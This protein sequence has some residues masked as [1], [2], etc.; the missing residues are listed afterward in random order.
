[1]MET[2]KSLTLGSSILVPSVQELA[3]QT[4]AEIPPR[5]IRTM[6]MKDC[7]GIVTAASGIGQ[8]I[9]VINFQNL[10]SPEQSVGDLELE[11]LH[12]ACK[13]WGFF[14]LVNHGVSSSLVEKVK[15][16]VY[17]LFKLPMEE[18][19]RYWQQEE[20]VEGFGQAFVVSEEQKLD[21]AD[22][23]FMTTLPH[24]ARKP[25]L[26]PKLPQ[27]L[28]DTLESYSS[29]LKILAMKILGRMAKALEIESN[30][31]SE[32]FENG[33]QNMRMNY[34][35]PCPQPE[36]VIG[37]TSHSDGVG[38]TILLQLN[39]VEGLQIKKEDKWVS[40]KPLPHAFIIN[41]G[42]ILEIVTNGIYPS[43]DHRATINSMKERLSVATF[44][45]PNPEGEIRPA[46]DLI[47][48]KTP[49]LFRSVGVTEY[50]KG[51]FTQKLD[52]KKY[53]DEMRI[54]PQPQENK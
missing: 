23:F 8:K 49:A 40:V 39:E 11:K 14:Q 13:Q 27:P 1:M 31:M 42:D 43:V 2:P 44:Y 10:L 53:L 51:L 3:K 30:F 48:S 19:K 54:H 50:F 46:A 18:K 28:R 5:Y 21:W 38:L 25:H 41:I 12:S 20:E 15:S 32:L 7:S 47:T 45:S 26:F 37:L 16:E 36:R 24:S 29:Q 52:G 35:P 22:I 4:L 17:D 34:Y 33:M 9:P 6:A